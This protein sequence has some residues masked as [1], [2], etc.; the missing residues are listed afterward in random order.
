MDLVDRVHRAK[1]VLENELDVRGVSQGPSRVRLDGSSPQD[2][3]ACC[4][5]EN[6]RQQAGKHRLAR[7]TLTDDGRHLA[8][9]QIEA[10]VVHRS[11]DSLRAEGRGRAL[12]P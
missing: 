10:Y 11:H 5:S 4:G 9:T 6:S 3:L 2:E 8:R 12:A 7:A 1:G